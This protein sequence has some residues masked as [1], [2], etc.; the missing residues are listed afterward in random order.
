[1]PSRMMPLVTLAAMVAS[2]SQ[3]EPA[4][5]PGDAGDSSAFSQ[6]PED[7][8]IRF[9]GTEPFWGGRIENGTLTYSTPENIDGVVVPV[10]R[11]AGRGG[12]SFSGE[13]NG[14]ALD[15]AITPAQCSDGMSDR[16]YPFAA[17]LQIGQERREGCAWREG[18]DSE[19]PSA[20]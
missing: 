8:V 9:T 20:Q 2:C 7:A 11:F 17:T 3:G 6:I 15:L 4:N 14:R 12:L 1:M 10:T 16:T 18:V 13:M 19:A 5:V